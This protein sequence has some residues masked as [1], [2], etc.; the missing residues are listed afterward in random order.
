MTIYYENLF[1]DD[2]EMLAISS[3]FM[4]SEPCPSG[5]GAVNEYVFAN[6][7]DLMEYIDENKLLKSNESYF[8]N[9]D[10]WIFRKMSYI[11]PS[12]IGV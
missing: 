10:S 4:I 9:I 3:K 7:E 12:N 5:S 8:P 2:I 6:G 11:F 1:D